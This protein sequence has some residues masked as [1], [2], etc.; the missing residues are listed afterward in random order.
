[1]KLIISIASTFALDV[2][3]DTKL[4]CI[5]TRFSYY[6]RLHM[7]MLAPLCIVALAAAGGVLWAYCARECC[8]E[9]GRKRRRVSDARQGV[10]VR[11][12]WTAA[13]LALLTIDLVYPTARPDSAEHFCR[14]KFS[15]AH[16]HG[17]DFLILAY[18]S[19]NS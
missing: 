2:F 3:S 12:L 16:S 7:A 15:V 9:S 18:C 1:M 4:P 13:P 17:L 14:L 10:V 8:P 6:D 11:G 19:A 5:L